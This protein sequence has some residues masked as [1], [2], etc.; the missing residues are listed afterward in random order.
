MTIRVNSTLSLWCVPSSEFLIR[1]W[2]TIEKHVGLAHG[3]PGWAWV[4]LNL[5]Q[6][7]HVAY[8]D[9]TAKAILRRLQEERSPTPYVS[10]LIGSGSYPLVAALAAH[11]DAAFL[12]VLPRLLH[13]WITSSTQSEHRDVMVGSAG[14]L[15]T[16]AEIEGLVPVESCLSL[17]AACIGW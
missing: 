13:H 3:W 16:C 5:V 9:R 6:T 14:A 10:H 1:R 7:G 4:W 2:P 12:K 15:L 11:T 8:Q 17:S